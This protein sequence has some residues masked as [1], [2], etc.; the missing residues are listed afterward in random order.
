M[1][2]LY[3]RLLTF[4]DA[5]RPDA[6]SLPPASPKPDGDRQMPSKLTASILNREALVMFIN[7]RGET[8]EEPASG[9]LHQVHVDA[10]ISED[11]L[12]LPVE[13]LS[14]RVI[15]PCAEA[16]AKAIPHGARFSPDMLELP[17]GVYGA[18]ADRFRGVALRTCIG[19]SIAPVYADG[20]WD[21]WQEGDIEPSPIGYEEN[22]IVRFDLRYSN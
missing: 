7:A 17:E 22:L 6:R 12:K 11:D 4:T 14:N 13:E 5:R 1:A 21:G 19:T 10:T 15:K 16:L 8:P 3:R 20:A 9:E 2:G 18:A